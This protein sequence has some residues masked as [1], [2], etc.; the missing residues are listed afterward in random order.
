MRYSAEAFEVLFQQP[1]GDMAVEGLR[2]KHNVDSIRTKT[3][4]AGPM[5]ECEIYPML[6][7]RGEIAAAK[8]EMKKAGTREAQKKLNARNAYKK[9]R[10]KLETNFGP[11]DLWVTL[12]FRTAPD[13]DQAV[14]AARNF[15]KRIRRW[16]KRH[17]LPELKYIYVLE[18]ETEG[19][20]KKRIHFHMVLSGMDRDV[21]EEL[22]D[23]GFANCRHL[24][25]NENGLEG[26]ARYMLKSPKGGR[27]WC[28]SKNLKDPIITVADKKIS[29]RMAGRIA[30]AAEEEAGELFGR[31]YPGY[32]LIECEVRRSEFIAGAYIYARM[33]K[34]DTGA[35]KGVKH[36]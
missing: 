5:L 3:I 27:R 35:G 31:A 23:K 18:Y 2:H 24:Q 1:I 13:E 21:V 26:L 17:G 29:K 14:K 4:K 36:R 33:R 28:C 15:I 8:L 16:R 20:Q 10:R 6:C 32:E 9:M 30:M 11:N 12:T 34:V 7:N 25:P 22:W 19:Q